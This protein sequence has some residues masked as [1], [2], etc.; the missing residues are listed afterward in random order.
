MP[1]RDKKTAPA[2]RKSRGGMFVGQVWK[3][4]NGEWKFVVA[5]VKGT[6]FHGAPLAMMMSLNFPLPFTLRYLWSEAKL[7]DDSYTPNGFMSESWIE[8][9]MQRVGAKMP[10]SAKVALRA[11]TLRRK[12]EAA[13][14]AA[15]G[16]RE[17]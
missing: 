2:A 17:D 3:H 12:Q 10:E 11:S 9:A 16:E 15:D 1:R 8:E 7:R 13:E 14:L 4:A 6:D 5:K